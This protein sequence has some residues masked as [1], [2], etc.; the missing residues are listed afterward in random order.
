MSG[1]QTSEVR[2]LADA[3][4]SAAGTV[5]GRLVERQASVGESIRRETPAPAPTDGSEL[6]ALVEL[7]SIGGKIVVR[8]PNHEM[9]SVVAIMFGGAED[10]GEMGPMQLSIL[11]ETVS[12]IAVAMAEALATELKVSPDTVRVELCTDPTLIPPPPF[13]S[14]RSIIE[15]GAGLAPTIGIDFAAIAKLQLDS[16]PEAVESQPGEPSVTFSEMQPTPVRAAPVGEANLDFVH[17]VPLRI[18]AVLGRSVMPLRD[19]VSLQSGS[20]FE[21]DKLAADPVDLYVNNVLIARGDVVVVDDK[22]AIRISELN[23]PAG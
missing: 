15:V 8:F 23:P 22:Y 16:A 5:L 10:L 4:L 9:R 3:M 12:Q 20:V 2:R 18:R 7:P 6:V 19:V 11:S 14:Y 21:L 17:D 1:A 13:E